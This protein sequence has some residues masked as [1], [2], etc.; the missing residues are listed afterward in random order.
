MVVGDDELDS[1]QTAFAQAEQEVPPARPAL[2]VGQLD[3]E[4][5]AAAV[6]IDADGDQHR[7][8]GDDAGLADPLVTGIEDQIGKGLD[9]PPMRE[10]R[11]ALV[12]SLVDPADPTGPAEGRPEGR[13][14]A[15][16][17][18]PH[19]SSVIA[20]TFRVDTPCTY[21]SA[22]AATSAFSER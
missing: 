7:L 10:L 21:I 9:Q 4:D 5:L 6:E 11:Q 12:Q 16:K 17:L 18:C 2:A 1:L 14:D 8:P 15:E 3:A 13:L 19:R 20:F 22:N